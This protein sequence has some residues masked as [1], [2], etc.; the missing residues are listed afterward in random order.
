VS[1]D[2]PAS[3]KLTGAGSEGV[4]FAVLSYMVADYLNLKID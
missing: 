3:S 2:S 1:I 4:S